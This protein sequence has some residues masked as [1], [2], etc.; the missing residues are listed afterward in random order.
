MQHV[1]DVTTDKG[2]LALEITFGGTILETVV[3]TF[4][5]CILGSKIDNMQTALTWIHDNANVKLPLLS[6]DA[7]VLSNS[8]SQELATPLAAA[9]VGSGKSGDEG[10]IGTIFDA[11]AKELRNQRIIALAF[12]AL[13]LLIVLVG[14]LVVLRHTLWPTS[15][16]SCETQEE[17][18]IPH[19]QG[20][21][22]HGEASYF[23][24]ED[25]PLQSGDVV[26]KTPPV[27]PSSTNRRGQALR[28][29][30]QR[31]RLPAHLRDTTSTQD[32]FSSPSEAKIQ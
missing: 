15:P 8:T 23:E 10:V 20:R 7:L 2:H 5:Y 22:H 27:S 26:E 11:Y 31:L 12:C 25:V 14:T 13:Y 29:I 4:M 1:I 24:L 3:N 9:A 19:V 30:W 32:S 6:L 17:A 18:C 21:R 28:A 16:D